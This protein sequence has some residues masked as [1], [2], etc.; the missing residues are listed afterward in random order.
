MES[1]FFPND[2]N[3]MVLLPENEFFNLSFKIRPYHEIQFRKIVEFLL[4]EGIIKENIIDLGAWIGDNSVPW[5]IM[6][7]HK[8]IYAIDPSE[9]NCNYINKIID[10]NNLDNL[11]VIPRAISDKIETLSTN[12]DLNH[13][14]LHQDENGKRKLESTSLDIL[15]KQNFI[16][17]VDFIHLDVEGM[18]YQVLLGAENLINRFRPIIAYEVHLITD[19]NIDNIKKFLISINY[20]IYLINEEL[21]G[22]NLDCR[23][24]LALPIEKDS[25]NLTSKLTK[26]VSKGKYYIVSHIG[27]RCTI[28]PY[29]YLNS[30]LQSFYILNNGS[31]ATVLMEQNLDYLKIIKNYGDS[32]CIKQCID[33]LKQYLETN[34][35]KKEL[36]IPLSL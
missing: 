34:D 8:I 17:N 5:S 21:P 12:D 32:G 22:C 4:K 26:Y 6:N 19:K 20:N 28:T 10:I 25:T 11:I 1:I 36:L 2:N 15:Y 31:Y 30:S 13:C 27:T 23:N 29:E 7:P 9:S 16:D 33:Y 3:S 14:T 35:S 24:C 18:E